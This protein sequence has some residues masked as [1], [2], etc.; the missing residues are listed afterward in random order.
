MQRSAAQ[1]RSDFIRYFGELHGHVFVPSSPVV[2][3]NDP[4]LL[5]TNAG[6]NQFKDVFLGQGKRPYTRAVNSQK[7]IRA[8]GKHNDLDDVGKDT[9]HHTFFE[10]LGNWSFG[11]YFKEEAIKWAWELLTRIWGLDKNRLYVTVFAGDEKDRL[12]PD[13][14]ARA[15]WQSV[16]DIDPGHISLWG[17]KDNFW[18]MGET[19]PCGPC[20]EIH[21]DQTEDG[22]G[23]GLVNKSDPRVIEIWN[24]VFI[25]FNRNEDGS[26][27]PL[28]ARHVDTGMGFERITRVLQGKSSNYDT[29]IWTPIF[30]AIEQRTGARGY[31]GHLNDPVDMAYRVIADHVRCLTFALTD[32]AMPGNEGRGYVLRRILRRG[33]RYGRQML[34]TS[35]AFMYHLVPAV[36]E[37]MSAAYPELAKHPRHVSDV[38][39]E[40]EE[41]FL[42]TLDRGI[43]LFTDSAN[44][45]FD[46]GSKEIPAGDAFK[47]HDTYG[48]PVDLTQLMAEERGM[49]VD[50]EGY[51]KLMEQARQTAR[52]AATKGKEAARFNLL[53]DHIA[54]LKHMKVEETEDIDKFHG[55]PIRARIK[56]IFN[57]ADFDHAAQTDT[58]GTPVAVITNKTNFYAEMG[59]Q[60]GDTGMIRDLSHGREGGGEFEV[61]DTQVIGGYVL[62]VGR[63]L[64]GKVTVGESVEMEVEH[65]RRTAIMSNH[66]ATHLLNLGLRHTLGEHVDQKGSLVAPERLRFDFAHTAALTPAELEQ[67]TLAVQAMIGRNLQVNAQEAG[68]EDARKINGL[69]AVFGERYPDPVRVVSI[70]PKVEELLSQPA[71]AK[72]REFSIEFCGG[73]HVQATGEIA[74]FSIT[75]EEAVAK[76]V[77]R[78]TAITG[79]AAAA[80]DAN[81]RFFADRLAEVGRASDAEFGPRLADVVEQIGQA[82]LTVLGR[83]RLRGLLEPLQ[84]RGKQLKKQA[85]GAGREA[86]V[87]AA[88]QIAETHSGRAIIAQLPDGASGDVLRA[89]LDAVK[90][91]HADSA[92]LLASADREAGK[93]SIIAAVPDALIKV[94]L[95][96]GDWVREA[97]KVC[98]GGGGGRPNMAEAGGKDPEKVLDA[99]TRA[100]AFANETLG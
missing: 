83:A 93:V 12:A 73:T 14:E 2:P 42:R 82:A 29:D 1:I 81:E 86:I 35:G 20:T 99:L 94:G 18:E 48:F 59:G 72:W 5:F 63:V 88:R 21:Y 37:A 41:S 15:L 87:T 51:E 96:A 22:S 33:V 66:T 58:L 32:G 61:I 6:M 11:D 7:C 34:G 91:K 40:E 67:V 90:M 56:A 62:H 75:G 76:G 98:G 69:R 17:K 80:A 9:Y 39:R 24:L 60:V 95:K 4:T 100:Q 25:Q 23:G 45:A 57:G 28:P 71:D 78:I 19:G 38:I 3:V 27:T 53:P 54:R 30:M 79:K 85:A 31:T 70:G 68:T 26:L 52:E 50:V 84:E 47:L 8:G 44:R 43:A 89:A 97:A 16:T 74:H 13:T 36:V 77:R 55:R 10:M 49:R 64:R 46:A 65:R 92:V